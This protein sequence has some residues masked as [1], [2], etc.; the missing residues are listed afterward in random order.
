MSPA[1]PA[2][3]AVTL[4][5]QNDGG[6]ITVPD[7][8]L[9]QIATRAAEQVDGLRA[10]RK[11]TVDVEARIVRLEVAA[12]R[13]E[14]LTTQGERVQEAVAAA[15]EAMCGLEVTVDVVFEELT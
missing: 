8:V 11:R 7:S 14:S 2:G 9:A 3:V 5:V 4:V 1:D 6:T 12:Q 15:F 13:G 10:R